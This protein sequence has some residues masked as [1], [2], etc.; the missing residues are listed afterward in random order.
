MQP[1]VTVEQRVNAADEKTVT[2][3]VARVEDMRR[4]QALYAEVYGPNYPLSI[5]SEKSRMRR[6]IESSRYYWLVAVCE[7]RI[8]ASL[9]YEMDP[10]QRLA[11]AFGAVVSKEF[12][13]RDLANIMMETAQK[14]FTRGRPMVDTVYATTRTVTTAP[15]KLTENLGFVK[16][17]I[18]PNVHKVF[19]YE[20]HCL[21]AYF[22]PEALKRRK[23]PAI[24]IPEV[25]PFYRLVC[26]QIEL[27]RP[28]FSQPAAPLIERNQNASHQEPLL[29]FEIISAP[30]FVRHRFEYLKKSGLFAASYVPF[31]E[32]N[33]LFITPDQ[34]TEVFLNHG[35]MDR[36]SVIL[37]GRTGS[38]DFSLIL[39]SAAKTL[40]DMG[41]SYI[42]LLVDAY[43]PALQRHAFNSRFIPC[44]YY[45]ALRKVGGKRWDYIVFARTFEMLDFRNVRITQTYRRFLKEYLK[46]WQSLYI[47]S[48]FRD[49]SLKSS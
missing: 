30:H 47:D 1:T 43:S 31:H 38:R 10:V 3:R 40:N 23:K 14:R 16:L 42:E 41:V 32:A 17:G 36:Y 45:P 24:L 4:V 2:L 11:K 6:A 9:I 21:A 39:N 25:A 13:K 35:A 18:F 46:I 8:I 7:D 44:A 49:S 5:V 33:L 15:Q 12:R 28:I 19:E 22:A 20:T 29:S 27:G 26:Q 34:S 37:G 48:V